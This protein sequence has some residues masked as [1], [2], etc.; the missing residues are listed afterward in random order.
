MFQLVHL[1]P[2]WSNNDVSTPETRFSEPGFS[3]I[4]DLMNKLQ[5]PFLY[6]NS[7]SRLDLVN[8]L[9]L[10][11]KKGLTIRF[12]KSSLECTISQY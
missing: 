11:N 7:L 9:N 5:L 10:V 3:E 8:R 2:D 1:G 6:L 4:F 12:T